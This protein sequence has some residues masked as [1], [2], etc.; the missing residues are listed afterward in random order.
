MASGEF[1][2]PLLNRTWQDAAGAKE[3]VDAIVSEA[4][5]DAVEI[6]GLPTL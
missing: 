3:R 2:N 6:R 1:H 5:K 4:R